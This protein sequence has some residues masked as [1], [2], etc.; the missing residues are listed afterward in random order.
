VVYRDGSG[1]AELPRRIETDAKRQWRVLKPGGL[2]WIGARAG[3]P[4]GDGDR[5]RIIGRIRSVYDEWGYPYALT[6]G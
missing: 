4:M 5:A 6:D 3:E 1:E 2:R